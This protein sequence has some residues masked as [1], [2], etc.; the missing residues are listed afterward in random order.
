M[1]TC[2]EK[3]VACRG[4]WCRRGRRVCRHGACQV[5]KATVPSATGVVKTGK[6]WTEVAS[7]KRLGSARGQRAWYSRGADVDR[8]PTQLDRRRRGRRP[9]SGESAVFCRR[10]LTEI[11]CLFALDAAIEGRRAAFGAHRRQERL[12]ERPWKSDF[13][14]P[15]LRHNVLGPRLKASWYV[16]KR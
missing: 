1:V 12:S 2:G 7:G 15:H 11:F 10:S 13:V 16:R 5:V 8:V 14:A 4:R 9:R 6:S 3:S